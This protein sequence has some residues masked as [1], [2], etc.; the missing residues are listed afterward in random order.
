MLKKYLRI[1]KLLLRLGLSVE[2]VKE[3]S[4]NSNLPLIGVEKV[5]SVLRIKTD[6]PV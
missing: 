1:N 3:F 5:T 4:A 6:P 2:A